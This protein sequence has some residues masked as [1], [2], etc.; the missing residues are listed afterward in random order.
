[1]TAQ[2]HNHILTRILIA[3]CILS[4]LSASML[5]PV[6]AD[7]YE[8]SP[9]YGDTAYIEAFAEMLTEPVG[10][11][12]FDFEQTTDDFLESETVDVI[13][14][15]QE[16]PQALFEKYS[17]RRYSGDMR[18]KQERAQR[19]QEQGRKARRAI[20]AKGHGRNK[21]RHEYSTIF[22][23]FALTIPESEIYELAAMQGVFGIFPDIKT[24]MYS[25]EPG[26]EPDPTYDF[27]GMRESREIFN[28][29]EIHQAGITGKGVNVCVIDTGID[30]NHPDFA[31]SYKGGKNYVNPGIDYARETVDDPD[32]PMETTY[33][34]WKAS[35]RPL[36]NQNNER[37]YMTHGTVVSGPVAAS[38]N[39]DNGTIR[40]LGMAPESNLYAARVVG[41]Y[42]AGYASDII[43]AIEDC[44]DEGGALPK[45]DVINLSVSPEEPLAFPPF[46]AALDN[47]VTAG[48]SVAIAAGNCAVTENTNPSQRQA[49]TMYPTNTASLPI[50]VAASQYGGNTTKSQN[51]EFEHLPKQ[52][53]Y[54][55]SVGPVQGTAAIKPDIIAPG[56][57]I[58]VPAPKYITNNATDYKNAYSMS[59]GTSLSSPIVAGI[60]TL[61][62]Q[63]YPDATPQELKARLMNTAKPDLIKAYDGGECSVFEVGA[64]FIDPFR[65]IVSEK[66]KGIY[67]TVSDRI[68]NAVI[69]SDQGKWIPDQ[70]LASMSF[71]HEKA[72]DM[73]R[74][75]SFTVHGALPE[76]IEIIYHNNTHFSDDS[77]ENGVIL[78]YTLQGDT[79]TTWGETP[80]TAAPGLYEG[81]IEI[82]AGGQKYTIP[83]AFSLAAEIPSAITF[84]EEKYGY[85]QQNAFRLDSY[86]PKP[87][88][89]KYPWFHALLTGKNSAAFEFAGELSK[90]NMITGSSLYVRPKLNLS[91]GVY[92]AKVIITDYVYAN[93]ETELS[94]TVL[95]DKVE[96]DPDP[97]PDPDPLPSDPEPPP[98]PPKTPA[99]PPVV[100]PQVTVFFNKN[101]GRGSISDRRVSRGGKVGKPSNPTRK[102]YVFSGWYRGSVKFDFAKHTVTA[103]TTL[104]ARWKAVK[105][106]IIRPRK[107]KKNRFTISANAPVR[108]VRWTT[109]KKRVL[110]IVRGAQNRTV[111][112]RGVSKGLAVVRVSV[113]F[114]D[115]T[116]KT[117]RRTIKVR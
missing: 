98:T 103:D 60:L 14:W 112:L 18:K 37:F 105:V 66:D 28:M 44:A 19:A 69:N 88:D 59:S 7:F 117:A 87:K 110:R 81:R 92:T 100:P 36:L 58:V 107:N 34:Q 3:I 73:T 108:T 17:G 41:P 77:S 16:L 75:I 27:N 6:A 109:S 5:L 93:Y 47:A 82:K 114:Q 25:A 78:K 97:D 53:A 24:R 67:I 2:K 62:K 54:F 43:A 13:V 101:G 42:G 33:D 57:R 50:I 79:V 45:M 99:P 80:E 84:P 52:P 104:T 111:T 96:P 10:A 72:G 61:M 21:I 63:V 64:G 26:F 116:K 15:L 22:S 29:A 35:G 68:P 83:W 85:N 71:G 23:G 90:K 38:A 70:T 65:A 106:R 8:E 91:Q 40:A 39:H 102:G 32:G 86:L 11:Q 4:A 55:S 49:Y 20:R 56:W 89:W 115:G 9:V 31:G 95:S 51:G 12:N 94:F 48:V 1:M 30:Y 46:T 113:R 74:E 76:S